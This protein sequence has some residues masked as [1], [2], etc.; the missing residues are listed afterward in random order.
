M[1]RAHYGSINSYRDPFVDRQTVNGP[2]DH[3]FFF[4]SGMR[5]AAAMRPTCTDDRAAHGGCRLGL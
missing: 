4:D 3:G 1:S 5:R 2:F